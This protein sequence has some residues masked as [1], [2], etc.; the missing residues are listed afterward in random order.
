MSFGCRRVINLVKKGIHDQSFLYFRRRLLTFQSQHVDSFMLIC[1]WQRH[2]MIGMDKNLEMRRVD[3]KV[4]KIWFGKGGCLIQF[5]P[6]I[7]SIHMIAVLSDILSVEIKT[8]IFNRIGL[9]VVDVS[10]IKWGSELRDCILLMTFQRQQTGLHRF[11]VQHGVNDAVWRGLS[12][13]LTL[14]S[15]KFGRLKVENEGNMGGC[16]E[17]CWNGFGIGD[18]SMQFTMDDCCMNKTGLTLKSQLLTAQSQGGLLLNCKIGN[19]KWEICWID[20]HEVRV[21]MD[22]ADWMCLYCFSLWSRHEILTLKDTPSV[23]VKVGIF[24]CLRSLKWY[25]YFEGL[26]DKDIWFLLQLTFQSQL[27]GSLVGGEFKLWIKRLC[28]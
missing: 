12:L 28:L 8:R 17:V 24:M 13:L 16:S 26:R 11:T 25:C 23:E 27:D 19:Q 4:L 22:K 2:N 7:C 3:G 6:W 15:Q 5:N 21:W 1:R 14:K 9:W 20:I 10:Y 18:R